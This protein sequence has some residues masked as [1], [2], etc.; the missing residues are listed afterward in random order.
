MKQKRHFL[1]QHFLS[2]AI[3]AEEIVRRASIKSSDTVLEIG[4]GTCALTK[5]IAENSSK[6]IT[7]EIDQELFKKAKG[8]LLDFPCVNVRL[9]DA[10][11]DYDLDFDVCV[12]SL[13]YSRSLDFIH[14][15]SLRSGGFRTTV[16][17]VQSDFA[18]KLLSLPGERNYR[19]VSVVSQIAFESEVL[20]DLGPEYFRP[21]PKVHSEV[22]RLTP[23]QKIHQPFFTEKRIRALRYLFSFRGRLLRN[24]LR[25]M[26]S[27]NLDFSGMSE[28]ML[29]RRIE[30]IAPIEYI[31]ILENF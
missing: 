31:P 19:A 5:H 4:T 25:S 24:A 13:P 9:G 27:R 17:I 28:E 29:S 3:T 14:W 21:S 6:V 26:K 12:T 23:N 20:M 18:A 22:I 15:L 11:K 8:Q 30:K 1:G 7:Y 2:S 10:F 16:A